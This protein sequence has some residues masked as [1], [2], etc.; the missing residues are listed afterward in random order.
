MMSHSPP[1]A[2]QLAL[3]ASGGRQN[4]KVEI[5]SKRY[6]VRHHDFPSTLL[7]FFTMAPPS[8]KLPTS[9][10]V[11]LELPPTSITTGDPSIQSVYSFMSGPTNGNEHFCR[12]APSV[13]RV[14]LV[15]HAGPEYPPVQKQT[16]SLHEPCPL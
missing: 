10:S 14:Y 6:F 3:Q 1:G 2:L 7:S 5:P 12:R 13:K 11:A 4:P 16:P 15:W 9:C 8:G